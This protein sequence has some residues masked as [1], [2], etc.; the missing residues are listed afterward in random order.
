M[1]NVNLSADMQYAEGLQSLEGTKTGW[2]DAD[3]AVRCFKCAADLDHLQAMVKLGECY[4][5][6]VGVEQNPIEAGLQY[7]KAAEGGSAEAIGHMAACYLKGVGVEQNISKAI[8]LYREAAER[9]DPEGQSGLGSCYE[10][11]EGVDKNL[12]EAFRWFQRSADN[13]SAEGQFSLGRCYFFGIGV[14][15]D[16]VQAVH[17]F[18][19]AAAQGKDAYDHFDRKQPVM[20]IATAMGFLGYCYDMGLGVEKDANRAE[21]WYGEAAFR[22]H[23]DACRKYA[24]ILQAASEDAAGSIEMMER[25]LLRNR[26]FAGRKQEAPP[27]S[28]F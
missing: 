23:P 11:G 10:E 21:H 14:A 26:K 12:E 9:N 24:A 5:H 27:S 20:T 3:R 2:Q 13:G 19:L 8:Q 7:M 22:Q 16:P 1:Q 17:W 6:G 25:L 28:T 4:E 15:V 18:N